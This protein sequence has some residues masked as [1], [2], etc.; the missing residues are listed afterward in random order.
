LSGLSTDAGWIR[1]GLTFAE[2]LWIVI[3]TIGVSVGDLRLERWKRDVDYMTEAATKLG[4][5][6]YATSADGDQGKKILIRSRRA[7]YDSPPG[8]KK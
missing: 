8:F 3:V 4:A 6:V 7:W 1:A 2:S 5:K